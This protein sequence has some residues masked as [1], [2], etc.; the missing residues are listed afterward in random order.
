MRILR[1]IINSPWFYWPFGVISLVLLVSAL[2]QDVAVRDAVVGTLIFAFFWAF[3]ISGTY[4][5]YKR[6]SD[7]WR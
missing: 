7:R 2:R 1:E 3:T 5:V 4:R 6:M